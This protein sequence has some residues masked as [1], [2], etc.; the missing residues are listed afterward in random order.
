VKITEAGVNECRG[1]LVR[2]LDQGTSSVRHD[3]NTAALQAKAL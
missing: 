2:V 1:Q 3:V